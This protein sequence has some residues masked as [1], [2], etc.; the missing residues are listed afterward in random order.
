[1]TLLIRHLHAFVH[2]AALTPD[3]WKMGIDFLTRTGQM[4]S[5][6]RQ[7]F[8]LLSDI[9]GVS[10]LV[11]AIANQA[12]DGITDSTVMGPFYTGL[13]RE[14]KKGDTILLREERGEPL[15]IKGRVAD[16]SGKPIVGAK[17]E[18]WQAAT[19]QLYDVQDENQPRG[20]LRA[21][22]TSDELGEYE[23]KTVMPPSYPIPNDG[24]AGQL[25]DRL[26]RHPFRPAHVHFMITAPPY[27]TLVT[28]LFLAGDKYLGSDAVFGVKPSLVV[29]PEIRDCGLTL[30][31]DFGL[32][33]S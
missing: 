2:E 31:Y 7:E 4:C 28:H 18:V 11:D 9:L 10:M 20:H 27:R 25:L 15:V 8:I 14:L 5:E 30:T 13:Q 1:M 21:T 17:V 16:A 32:A 24:P 22:F 12:G 29:K 26:G 19:N 6:N 33:R 3:E 23:F